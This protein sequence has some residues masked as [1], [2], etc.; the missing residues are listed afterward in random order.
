[1]PC[2]QSYSGSQTCTLATDHV[3]QTLT[4]PTGGAHYALILDVAN[5]V[6][7]EVLFAYVKRKVRS[8]DTERELMRVVVA[9]GP[10]SAPIVD[11]L[12]LRLPNGIAGTFGIRQ[13]GGTGRSI[14]WAVERVDG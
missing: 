2:T 5:I 7:A 13:E 8:S 9:R 12:I 6:A 14:P 11:S 10:A 4:G 3:V 1:M